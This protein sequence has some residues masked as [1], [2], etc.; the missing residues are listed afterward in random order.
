MINN[1]DKH[2]KFKISQE[3]NKTIN[4]LDLSVNRTANNIE[5][6]IYRKHTYMDVTVHFTSNHPYDQ[7]LAAFIF[8]INRLTKMPIMKQVKKQEWNK[9]NTMAQNNGIPKHIIHGL[10][11]K[12]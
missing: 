3:I 11:G 1:T 7:K 2:L 4:Y 10:R 6:N 8:Y 12:N 5:L 9:I